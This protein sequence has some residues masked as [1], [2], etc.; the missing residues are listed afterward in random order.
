[1][2]EVS[3][4]RRAGIAYAS[5]VVILAKSFDSSEEDLEAL[6]DADTIFAYR[7]STEENPNVHI[8]CELVAQSNTNFLMNFSDRE[9]LPIK[10]HH[11]PVFASGNTFTSSMLDTLVCQAYYNPHII[12]ILHRLVAASDDTEEAKWN[13]KIETKLGCQ[14][15]G[16]LLYLNTVPDEFI[17]KTYG[18]L[19]SY[20]ISEKEAIPLGLRRAVHESSR[21]Y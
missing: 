6:V 10:Q 9:E 8:I 17:G 20:M 18:E 3:N 1:M 4:L 19:F 5:R 16:S 15:Q 2:L 21:V 13:E 7:V 14:L 11:S 12:T